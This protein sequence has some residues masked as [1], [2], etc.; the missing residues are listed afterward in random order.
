MAKFKPGQSGN[1]GGRP[2]C[3]YH[4]SR[5]VDSILDKFG[6]I[7]GFCRYWFKH[8]KRYLSDFLREFLKKE[9]KLEPNHSGGL[10]VQIVDRFGK[11]KK[12]D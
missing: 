11:L 3:K 5:L 12:H 10:I 1:P 9:I 2:R 8:D 4:L 7:N 6:G